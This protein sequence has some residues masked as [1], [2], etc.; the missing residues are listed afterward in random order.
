MKTPKGLIILVHDVLEPVS[1]QEV[2]AALPE[3]HK[4]LARHTIHILPERVKHGEALNHHWPSLI[5]EQEQA[6]EK[7]VLPVI[8]KHKDYLILYFGLAPI[9]LAI[10]LGHKIQSFK[11]AQVYLRDHTTKTWEWTDLTAAK[12]QVKGVPGE[13]F[14]GAGEVVIRLG[15]RFEIGEADTTIVVPEAIKE[16][17]IYPQQLGADIFGS[18]EQVAKY[19]E[20][21]R[22][23]LDAITTQL[24][25]VN[26]VHLFA[27]IPVGL[28]FLVGQEISP[29]THP[30]VHLYEYAKDRAPKYTQ[31]YTVNK[32]YNANLLQLTERE[33]EKFQKLRIAFQEELA[34][35]AETCVPPVGRKDK[36]HWFNTLPSSEESGLDAFDHVYWR[37]LARL[38]QSQL[39]QSFLDLEKEKETAEQNDYFFEDFMLKSLTASLKNKEDQLMACRLFSMRETI[40]EKTHR[41]RMES[42]M[43]IFRYPRVA[44]EANYQSDVYALV[45]DFFYEKRPKD[46]ACESFKTMI[47]VITE[48]MWAFDKRVRKSDEMEVQRVNRYLT[49]YYLACMLETHAICDLKSILTLLAHKPI[50]EL[51]LQGL[52]TTKGQK[53]VFDFK[54]GNDTDLGICLFHDG[55]AKLFSVKVGEEPISN[56]IEGFKTHQP[57]KIKAVLAALINEL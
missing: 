16:I 47:H 2:I 12:P 54:R 6:F 1:D 26:S 21:F 55:R 42:G 25:D 19:A 33:K 22:N 3:S 34:E 18:H 14:K 24:Q 43:G 39:K 57:E 51:R 46:E 56:L 7:D 5:A 17:E 11:K 30:L 9:A 50:I 13:S 49:W 40:H 41:V 45:H 29:T 23:A 15:T 36:E 38:D 28:A 32:E 20:A 35:F 10:H 27:A 48:T 4:A 44:E 52:Q 53:I 37:H 31:V 8:N